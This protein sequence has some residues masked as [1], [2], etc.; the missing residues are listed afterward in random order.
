[1]KKP[2]RSVLHPSVR[3]SLPAVLWLLL[4]LSI[5]TFPSPLLSSS[6][7]GAGLVVPVLL[8]P[9]SE[10]AGNLYF[11]ES[12]LEISCSLDM[13]PYLYRSYN[14]RS[15]RVGI[16]GRGWTAD[17]VDVRIEK[18]ADGSRVVV[19]GD[20]HEEPYVPRNDGEYLAGKSGESEGVKLAP[21]NEGEYQLFLKNGE[22]WVFNPKGY[23]IAKQDSFGNLIA[24]RRDRD[25]VTPMTIEGSFGKSISL[26]H[27]KGRFVAVDGTGGM[28]VD[29]EFDK[30]GRLIRKAIR[31]GQETDYGYDNA[32]ILDRLRVRGGPQ[33]KF[34]YAEGL[35]TKYISEQGTTRNYRLLPVPGGVPGDYRQEITGK[36]G[37]ILW[38]VEVRRSGAERVVIDESQNRTRLTFDER[39]NLV[40]RQGPEGKEE[41]WRYGANDVLE[42][43]EDSLGNRTTYEWSRDGQKLEVTLPRGSRIVLAYDLSGSLISETDPWGAEKKYVLD[44]RGRVKEIHYDGKPLLKQHYDQRGYIDNVEGADGSWE[45]KR[46]A[47]GNITL[48]TDVMGRTVSRKSNVFGQPLLEKDGEGRAT[49]WSYDR[50]GRLSN[51]TDGAGNT[52]N[53]SFSQ[54][55]DLNV[56]TDSNGSQYRYGHKEGFPVSLAFPNGSVERVELDDLGRVTKA[57]NHRGQAVEYTRDK[58]GRIV[59]QT[60]PGGSN[61][62]RYDEFGRLTGASN[63]HS[64]YEI[65]YDR[66]GDISEIRD[67]KGRTLKYRYNDKGQRTELV[68]SEEG[69]TT[70]EYDSRGNLARI[71]GPLGEIYRFEYDGTGRLVKRE[72]PNG[73][74]CSFGYDP[75]G[76]PSTVQYRDRDGN[77]LYFISVARDKSGRIVS[78]RENESN[79]DYRYDSA[80]RLV[81]VKGPEG[82]EESFTYDRAGNRVAHQTGAGSRRLQ[83][84]RMNEL[85]NDGQFS[86]RYDADGLPISRSDGVR[87]EF[88]PLGQLVGLKTANGSIRYEYD[89]FGRLVAREIDGERAEYLFDMEDLV[90]EYKGT[91]PTTRYLHGPDI[92]EPLSFRREGKLHILLSDQNNTVRRVYGEDGGMIE[93]YG[94]TPFGRITRPEGA[95][96]SR[97]LFNSRDWDPE[98]GLYNIRAR[99]YDPV[100]G[101]FISP[102]PIRFRGGWNLYAYA[103]NDPLNGVDLTGLAAKVASF[104]AFGGVGKANVYF[105][106]FGRNDPRNGW[107]VSGG[108]GINVGASVGI[109]QSVSFTA[110]KD[111]YKSFEGPSVSFDVSYSKYL[112]GILGG[113]SI[114]KSV[115][116]FPWQKDKDPWVTFDQNIAQLPD[117]FG[118]G[119][120]P[121]PGVPPRPAPGPTTPRPTPP[122]GGRNVGEGLSAG[123]NW[124]F[125]KHV[126]ATNPKHEVLTAFVSPAEARRKVGERQNFTF[127][128]ETESPNERGNR[129]THDVTEYS[130]WFA[131]K[132]E[133]EGVDYKETENPILCKEKGTFRIRA[134][135][136]NDYVYNPKEPTLSGAYAFASITCHGGDNVTVSP[137]DT[138]SF[139]KKTYTFREDAGWA[140]IKVKR[141]GEASG[142]VIVRLITE[143]GTAKAGKEPGEGDYD[144]PGVDRVIWESKDRVDKT[145]SIKINKDDLVEGTEDVKL[146]LEV[147]VGH[148]ELEAAGREAILQITDVLPSGIALMKTPDSDMANDGDRVTYTFQV[149]NT[150]K[151][152]LTKV[153]IIDSACVD[154][155]VLKSGDS[156]G[157]NALDPGETWVYECSVIVSGTGILTNTATVKARDPDGAVVE[158]EATAQVDVGPRPIV[159]PNVIGLTEEEAV[160]AIKD[161][162]LF[163]WKT[164]IKPSDLAVGLACEQVPKAGQWESQGSPV[165][166]WISAN[167]PK[168]IFLDPPR[169]TLPLKQQVSFEATLIDKDGSQNVLQP[170]EVEWQPGP[171]NTFLCEK[172]GKFIVGAKYLWAEVY[173]SAT[174]TCEEDWSVPSYEPPITSARDRG[175]K[176]PRPGPGDYKWYV[177]CDPRSGEVTYGEHLLTGRRTMAGPFPGPRTAYDWIQTNCSSWRCNANGVCAAAPARGGEW[178]VLCDRNDRR[179]YLGKTH[180]ASRFLLVQEG[181]LGEPD[182]RAWADRNYPGWA[183]TESGTPVAGPQTGSR[184]SVVCSKRHGG[185]S[186]T[187]HPDP[188][189]YYIWNDNFFSEPDARRWTDRNCP[190]WRCDATGRCL[191]GAVRRT[192]EGRPLE[193]PPEGPA[194]EGAQEPGRQESSDFWSRFSEGFKKGVD[195]GVS[196]G[197]PGRM[198]DTAGRK[199]PPA[200]VPPPPPPPVGKPP[201]PAPAGKSTGKK[202]QGGCAVP[203]DSAAQKQRLHDRIGKYRAPRNKGGDYWNADIVMRAGYSVGSEKL[204]ATALELNAMGTLINDYHACYTKYWAFF[205]IERDQLYKDLAATEKRGAEA[206]NNADRRSAGEEAQRIK[207]RIGQRAADVTRT[208]NKCITDADKA[209]Q[210]A[211]KSA[212]EM[213]K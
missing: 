121:S 115:K 146:K 139:T 165:Q 92:D 181:F 63:A 41:K 157:D 200:A 130:K 56:F 207:N 82:S 140:E 128:I 14:S 193:V 29:Y 114:S 197:Q 179:I 18:Q 124:T 108:P 20:G 61:E 67:G 39:G 43:H 123:I 98:A 11:S 136:I 71:T 45:I 129:K 49:T 19:M 47:L 186:L 188:V 134:D 1:M 58:L 3:S 12:D 69:R 178:K 174:V 142:R 66:S 132:T 93:E 211:I 59:K 172:P 35:L 50:Y 70:Y 152:P 131:T 73:I 21:G 151:N 111:P 51:L 191:T 119:T 84:G 105:V 190:S 97:F 102:D 16:F 7:A 37:R 187:Q 208:H 150:G 22:R 169:K 182:A 120:A 8:G 40:S 77:P 31:S 83:Y 46:D 154:N 160:K 100:A 144:K 32:G 135:Y 176:L 88:N 149:A 209:F 159:V 95:P 13:R 138:I 91:L 158:H 5:I 195:E 103:D 60:F 153:E 163:P 53:F 64:A 155:I 38:S 201:V 23:L 206:R 127:K 212:R 104:G 28:R 113:G 62:W 34:A 110:S 177:Y 54:E 162:G 44:Q 173:G 194:P 89:P 27:K 137:K 106:D 90:A 57:Y 164:G 125:G 213:C 9:G 204:P 112:I 76:L 30:R 203:A 210:S 133:I 118:N 202:A 185:V 145:F 55:G 81:R 75:G 72:Y 42:F 143:D 161:A 183:C 148:A 79:W 101:R 33:H 80:G 167:V 65:R 26:Q 94:M 147:T 180:D 166:F 184:W 189:D 87:Y 96:A 86:Y 6:P 2:G 4:I 85:L 168:Y 74:R 192:P 117:D 25:G 36:S 10:F 126:V 122:G 171:G 170:D 107:Y 109:S 48:V 116:R 78:R 24:I 175:A 99:F 15:N 198:P 199:E 68:D 52:K 156:D 205:E 196:S 141:R 17:P